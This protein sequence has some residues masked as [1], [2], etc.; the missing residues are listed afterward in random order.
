MVPVAPPPCA[1]ARAPGRTR[2]RATATARVRQRFV[3][4]MWNS[5]PWSDRCHGQRLAGT[6]TNVTVQ[7]VMRCGPRMA[8]LQALVK[9]AKTRDV[10]LAV[11]A[12][13]QKD[14]H[15]NGDKPRPDQRVHRA[16]THRTHDHKDG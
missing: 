4:S 3:L 5:P 7:R 1:I 12:L 14:R 10:A 16:R 11:A 9:E 15:S 13:Q 6:A 8:A 2:P